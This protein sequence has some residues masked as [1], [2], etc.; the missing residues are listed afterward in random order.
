MHFDLD[1]ADEA[2]RDEVRSFLAAELPRD[3]AARTRLDQRPIRADVAAWNRILHRKGWSAP[4]WPKAHGGT[5]WSPICRHIF[6]QECALAD[7]PELS[8]FGHA[9]AG[10]VIYTFGN[11][12][13]KKIHLPGILSGD[14]FWC[15]GFSE[16]EAGS[17]LAALR[18]TARCDGDGWIISGRKIWT[19]HA[20]FSDWMFCLA[21]TDPAAKPQRGIS[22]FVFRMD[23]P[24]IS[25]R[26]ILTIDR[27]HDVNE[28]VLDDVRVP[29]ESLVGELNRGWDYAKFLLANERTYSA[30]IPHSTR[31]FRRLQAL[32]RRERKGDRALAED[33][34]FS[35]KLVEAEIDLKTLEFAVLRALSADDVGPVFAAVLKLRG[36]ELEQR[37][38]S[39]AVE[40]LGVGALRYW[41]DPSWPT[42]FENALPGEDDDPGVTSTHL[43]LRAA[44]IY[45]GTNEIQRGLIAND[46]LGRG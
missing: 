23:T 46:L 33:P 12:T 20:H 31:A 29:A 14:V 18:T 24:G 30:R 36:S 27:S 11:E 8:V 43:F 37:L 19:T 32:A 21:R 15:Q 16:P 7:A 10:P 4:A 40:A 5:G 3:L 28:V 25:I 26:P 42:Q 17:D 13:Q 41:P 9:L 22:F 39:L 1:P 2:F 38:T 44:T 35:R 34:A 45:S 6:A